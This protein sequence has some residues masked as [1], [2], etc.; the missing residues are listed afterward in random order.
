MVT[1]EA[2]PSCGWRTARALVTILRVCA[3]LREEFVLFG[4][5]AGPL[6]TLMM[7]P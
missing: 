6:V 1:F 2:I 5:A 7:M 4:E 3:P